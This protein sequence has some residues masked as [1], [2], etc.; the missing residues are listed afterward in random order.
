LIDAS[1]GFV[2]CFRSTK[3]RIE[4][5]AIYSLFV[6]LL[7]IVLDEGLSVHLCVTRRTGGEELVY[8]SILC[9]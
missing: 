1:E 5:L 7:A 2:A 9:R 4:M 3:R 8:R 6:L